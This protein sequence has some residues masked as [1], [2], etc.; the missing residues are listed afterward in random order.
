[1]HNVSFYL[2]KNLAML[3][4]PNLG[5]PMSC[6]QL[7]CYQSELEDAPCLTQSIGRA[8]FVKNQ[9]KLPVD[10]SQLE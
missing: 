3:S 6:F 9:N 1:M 5:R 10:L 4:Q 2:V 8:I 7:S